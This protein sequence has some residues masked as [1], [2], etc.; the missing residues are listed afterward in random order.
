MNKLI[1]TIL[2]LILAISSYFILN[3]SDIFW[4]VFILIWA[5]NIDI[6]NK[7]TRL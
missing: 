4:G 7:L 6:S 5:N 2:P 1:L 3:N